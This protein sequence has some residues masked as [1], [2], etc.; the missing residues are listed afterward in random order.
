MSWVE[1]TYIVARGNSTYRL[2]NLSTGKDVIQGTKRVFIHDEYLFDYETDGTIRISTP[3]G[4]QFLV[5]KKGSNIYTNG[6]QLVYIEPENGGYRI[7]EKTGE[8]SEN[9]AVTQY[10]GSI[11]NE[12]LLQTLNKNSRYYHIPA[13]Q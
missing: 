13:N 8:E 12:E 3:A 5:A 2:V 7:F 6:T 9:E 4:K 11:N 10:I 1:G